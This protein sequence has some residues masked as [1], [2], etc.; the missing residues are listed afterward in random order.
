MSI[1]CD[2]NTI[3]AIDLNESIGLSLYTINNN[4]LALKDSICQLDTNFTVLENRNTILK[5]L[6]FNLNQQ[7]NNV[8]KAKVSFDCTKNVSGDIDSLDTDRFIYSDTSFNVTRV[9]RL[10]GPA[11]YRIFFTTNLVTNNYAIIGT[12][13]IST[14]DAWVQ[15][16][17]NGFNSQHAT[18]SILNTE[19]QYDHPE[20]VSII[21]L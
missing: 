21:M 2:D 1:L 5:N 19:G 13:A 8:I 10:S 17:S 12:N 11:R 6:A 7:K 18:I 15:P 16:L 3:Q 4:F 14:G 9:Q 20:H